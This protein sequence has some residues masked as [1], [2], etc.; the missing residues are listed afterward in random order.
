MFVQNILGVNTLSIF[1]INEIGAKIAD[2]GNNG[3][4]YQLRQNI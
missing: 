2:L 4:E 3:I 1:G